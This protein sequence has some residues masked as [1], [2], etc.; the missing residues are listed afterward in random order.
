MIKVCTKCGDE[1]DLSDFYEKKDHLNGYRSQCKKCICEG[2]KIW[3]EVQPKGYRK[4][5]DKEYRLAHRQNRIE[6]NNRNR[7]TWDITYYYAHIEEIRKCRKVWLAEHPEYHWNYDH[8]PNGKARI[9]RRAAKRREMGFIS[10][11]KPFDGAEAHHVDKERVVFIPRNL[12]RSVGHSVLKNINM[13]KINSL[14]YDFLI[15]NAQ[16]Q[17]SPPPK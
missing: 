8:S 9:R 7:K 12:H 10:V 14:A 11:N 1:K 3:R 16:Q 6:Y 15:S 13:E 5:Y 4:S 17:L 2:V